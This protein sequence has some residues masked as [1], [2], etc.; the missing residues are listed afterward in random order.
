MSF[1]LF[2]SMDK[3]FA[4]INIDIMV[5]CT[6]DYVN[7]INSILHTTQDVHHKDIFSTQRIPLLKFLIVYGF[8]RFLGI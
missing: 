7:K 2:L 3:L 6:Y 5:I 1:S 8:I 4:L